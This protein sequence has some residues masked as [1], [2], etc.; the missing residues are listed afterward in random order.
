MRKLHPVLLQLV[1]CEQQVPEK[2][3]K[4]VRSQWVQLL[5][6]PVSATASFLTRDT[7]FD[8]VLELLSVPLQTQ[9][10]QQVLLASFDQL[11]ENVEVP[12]S[13]VLVHHARLLQQVV[14]DVASHGRALPP[15]QRPRR[16]DGRCGGG[17]GRGGGEGG[18]GEAGVLRFDAGLV[19]HAGVQH[20]FSEPWLPFR[21]EWC[22]LRRRGGGSL[23]LKSNW[24]SMY[25]PKRLELSL[26]NVLALP[27]A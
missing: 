4:S 16:A 10:P 27:K 3:K 11:I 24:M 7:H 22:L 23:T 21:A 26:R 13:V 20:H 8:Q 5:L 25:F 9:A 15:G 12:L 17:G 2:E 19:S 1:K 18:E 14:D 6:L